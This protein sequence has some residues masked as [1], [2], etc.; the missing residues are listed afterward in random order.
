MS[1]NHAAAPPPPPPAVCPS[2]KAEMPNIGWNV[3][4]PFG[5]AP[6]MPALFVVFFCAACRVAFSA[7]LLPIQGVQKP[8]LIIPGERF[9]Q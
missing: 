6:G 4:G 8:S 3:Q 9:R 2:C 7:Q 5:I 1:E